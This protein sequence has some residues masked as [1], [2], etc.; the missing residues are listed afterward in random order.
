MGKLEP[1]KKRQKDIWQKGCH[2]LNKTNEKTVK[3]NWLKLIAITNLKR[4]QCNPQ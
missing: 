2:V 1:V 4:K 3:E